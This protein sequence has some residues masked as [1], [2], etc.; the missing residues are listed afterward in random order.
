MHAIT[1][2][3]CG[4]PAIPIRLRTVEEEVKSTA[5]KSPPLIASL[6]GCG[7]GAARTVR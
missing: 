2:F 3:G 5:S 1:V 4:L 6:T 7:G